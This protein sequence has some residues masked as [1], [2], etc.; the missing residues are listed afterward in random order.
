MYLSIAPASALYG[1]AAN[2]QSFPFNREMIMTAFETY[3]DIMAPGLKG[4]DRRNY[5]HLRWDTIMSQ[6]AN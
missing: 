4:A 2:A 6:F 3:A 1:F 5:I